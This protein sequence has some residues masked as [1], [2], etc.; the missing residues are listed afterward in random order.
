MLFDDV[1]LVDRSAE[2]GVW[3]VQGV[4]ALEAAAELDAASRRAPRRRSPWGGVDLLL[5]HDN[6]AAQVDRLIGATPAADVVLEGLRVLAGQPQWPRD[7]GVKRLPSELG[8]RS[9][10]LSF[11]KGC[12]IGQES[13]NRIDVMGKVRRALSLVWVEGPPA[14]DGTPVATEGGEVGQWTSGV[15][16][17]GGASVGL[18]VLRTPHDEVG[19]SVRV[20]GVAGRVVARPFLPG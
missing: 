20:D 3:T 19:T 15:A 16:L 18:A 11:D 1:E 13:V 6:A 4:R 10:H 12:Y 17:A 7:I 8:V 2:L 14:P 5:R 9:T